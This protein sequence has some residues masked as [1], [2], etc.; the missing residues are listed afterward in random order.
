LRHDGLVIDLS[1]MRHVTVHVAARTAVIAGGATARDVVAAAVPHGLVA[2]TGNCGGV[3]MAGLTL[4]GGYG[5]L[6]SRFGLALDNLLGA[7]IVLADGRHITADALEHPDLFWALRGGGGNF[8]VVTSM[9]VRLHPIREVLAGLILF[10]WSEATRVLRG[11]AETVASAPD[12]LAVTAG[13]LS[14]PDCNP[15]LFLA[16]VWSGEPTQ[17]ERILDGL[18]RLGTPIAASIG[19]M[20]YADLLSMFDTEIVNGRHYALQTRWLPELTPDVIASLVAAGSN[21]TS[22]LAMIAMHHFHGAATRIPEVGSAFGLRREHF[23]VEAIAAWDP[24]D[25]ENG[26]VHRA[27]ARNLSRVLSRSALPGGYANLLGPDDHDQIALAHGANI[28]RLRKV[29][30]RFDPD[31]VF[32]AIPLSVCGTGEAPAA[33][34]VSGGD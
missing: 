10:P 8:G 3:G 15:A 19:P 2:V 25:E 5:P 22:P 24:E 4:G 18:K 32:S 14:G 13:M 6:S 9:R 29:K 31:N 33:R 23:L 12:E 21:R 28:D 11:Y 30:Q 27:W 7:E 1:A 34:L 17:G 26:A 20:N 16:P